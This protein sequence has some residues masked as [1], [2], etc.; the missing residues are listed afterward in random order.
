MCWI[1]TYLGP[2]DIIAHN[3]GKNFISREFKQYIIN[4]GT[5]TKSIPVK[6]YNL[7]SIVKHYYGLLQCIYHIITF[8][9]PGINKDMALQM[10]FK[11]INNST[12][13]DSLIPTLLIFR[14]YPQMTESNTSSLTVT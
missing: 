2:P 14:A 13:P 6:A 4:M 12:G 8:K 9:I 1:N 7:I 11:V 10:A 3:T 5:I